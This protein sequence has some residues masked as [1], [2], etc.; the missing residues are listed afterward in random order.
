MN[1]VKWGG[2]FHSNKKSFVDRRIDRASLARPCL[3]H[4]KKHRAGGL[5]GEA[6]RHN[7]HPASSRCAGDMLGTFGGHRSL[8]RIEFRCLY[9]RSR[10][11]VV[12]DKGPPS[13][14]LNY[15]VSVLL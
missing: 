9:S 5:G 4:R 7:Q 6:G 8:S 2:K 3:Q 13:C 1:F 11:M 12:K 15:H 14:F 10:V